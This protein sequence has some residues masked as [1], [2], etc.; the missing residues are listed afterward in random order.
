MEDRRGHEEGLD[1]RG[2]KGPG[3]SQ[4]MQVG[5]SGPRQDDPERRAGHAGVG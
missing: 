2:A 1:T 5:V 4:D 3:P